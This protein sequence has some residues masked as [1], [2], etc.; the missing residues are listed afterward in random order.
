ML[1]LAFLRRR[2]SH[3]YILSPDPGAGA[4]LLSSKGASSYRELESTARYLGGDRTRPD[5]LVRLGTGHGGPE[6]LRPVL[7]Q[8]PQPDRPANEHS[9]TPTDVSHRLLL[10]GMIGLPGRWDLSPLL[11]LRRGFPWSAVNEF[12]DFVGPRNRTGRLPFVRTLDISLVR[13]FDWGKH[14]IRAG[15][16]AYNLLGSGAERDMQTNTT[17]P[18]YGSA[19]NPVQRSIGIVLSTGRR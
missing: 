6:Q 14:H 7:R 12:Q 4:L 10:R 16:R 8:L 19:F 5:A 2:G 13:P 1:K 11:E 17:S 3:E 9:L 18:F 15:V